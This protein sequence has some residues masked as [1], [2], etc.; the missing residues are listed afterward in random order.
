MKKQ[1]LEKISIIYLV[2]TMKNNSNENSLIS[3]SLYNV[4]YKILNILFP[5]ISTS[6]VSH[7]INAD[8]VGKVASAQNIVQYFVI[9]ATLGIPEY[10]VREIAK[11]K[12]SKAINKLFSE[13]MLL[14]LV[15][16]I[17]CSVL[18]VV[19][20]YFNNYFGNRALYLVV[21]IS[22]LLNIINVDWL[23]QGIEEYKY[24]AIR[25]FVVKCFSLIAVFIF[26][27]ER[28]DYVIYALISV[29]AIAG[30]YGFNVVHLKRKS[31]KVRRHCLNLKIHFNSIFILLCT[32]ISIE[33]YTLLDT[34][35]L[36]FMDVEENVGYYT[37]SMR[38]VKILIAAVTGISGVLLP[39][40]SRYYSEGRVKECSEIVSKIFSILFFAFFPCGLGIIIVAPQLMIVLFGPS[41]KNGIITLR[42][43]ALLIYALGFS[44][45]FGTQV[46][47][48]VGCEKK[49]F[50]STIVGAISNI[51]MNAILIPLYNQNGAAL[52]S[53]ISE[54][55]VTFITYR[56]S[57]KYIKM[58]ID[59]KIFIDAFISVLF[60]TIAVVVM[61]DIITAELISLLLSVIVGI[62]IYLLINYILKNP[63][64]FELKRIVKKKN[65]CD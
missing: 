8:G 11:C 24:I 38:I 44:N 47:L 40:L 57:I 18:Y 15:S 4:L 23:Y 3:N 41:F 50:F 65:I 52:A 59:K 39:R 35:M 63:I 1:N 43:A 30:N 17:T 28:S 32:T 2:R 10:G 26:V 60:M 54:A 42:I 51:C 21:G 53:V 27:R 36:T 46:L 7:I 55:L 25:S 16:T 14:N 34:T 48:T 5:L 20:I 29:L 58:K 37:V 64:Y 45:L 19:V 6:Y 62:F 61:S 9:I 33:L 13:L 12:S 22:I 49:L 56:Y 31:V